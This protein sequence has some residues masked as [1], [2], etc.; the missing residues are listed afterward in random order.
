MG[1][2]I[3]A[4]TILTFIDDLN[5]KRIKKCIDLNPEKSGRFLQNSQISI[6]KASQEELKDIDCILM[7]MSIVEKIVFENEILRFFKENQCKNLKAVI[8]TAKKIELIEM[9]KDEI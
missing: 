4:N 1:G 8:K 6:V 2:G 7:A 3:H 9:K 5:L